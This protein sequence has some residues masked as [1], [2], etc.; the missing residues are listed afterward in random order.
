MAA[1]VKAASPNVSAK[2]TPWYAGLGLA[3]SE[4]FSACSAQGKEPPSMRA[5]PTVDPEPWSHFVVESQTRS[6]P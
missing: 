5:P 3:I 6:A 2:L 4:Y 1:Y